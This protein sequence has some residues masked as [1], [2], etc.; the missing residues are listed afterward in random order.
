MT[1]SELLWAIEKV[2]DDKKKHNEI[3]AI[4]KNL[5]KVTN[6]TDYTFNETKNAISIGLTH[7]YFRPHGEIDFLAVLPDEC[8][9]LNIEVKQQ[10]KINSR[11]AKKLLKEASSQM[12]RNEQNLARL[13]SPMLSKGWRLAKVAV[14]LPGN[15]KK[16]DKAFHFSNP[17]RSGSYQ[18][19]AK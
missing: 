5:T 16:G 12:K 8:L 6:K 14:I 10:I 18:S 1:E 15:L 3:S 17:Y 13:L 7:H 11:N 2:I 4:I 9:I 19:T